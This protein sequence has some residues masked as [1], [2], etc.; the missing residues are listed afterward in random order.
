MSIDAKLYQ[1][2]VLSVPDA[3]RIG[4][5]AALAIEEKG[6]RVISC[7]ANGRRPVLILDRAPAD[8]AGHVK[9][10]HPNGRGG[11]TQTLAAP[12]LGA[13]LEW[14][15]DIERASFVRGVVGHA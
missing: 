7:Y 8:V 6:C 10:R 4:A 9:Q 13:Q 12:F 3:L 15:Q 2:D 1:Q 14:L 5:D 11:I